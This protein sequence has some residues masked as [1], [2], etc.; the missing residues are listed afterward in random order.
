MLERVCCL[1]ESLYTPEYI[2]DTFNLQLISVWKYCVSST[3]V[4]VFVVLRDDVEVTCNVGLQRTRAGEEPGHQAEQPPAQGAGG[5][6][7]SP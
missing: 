6:G 7:D 2:A 3:L 4:R 1:Q 5:S